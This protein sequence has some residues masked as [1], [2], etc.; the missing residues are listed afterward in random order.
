[1]KLTWEEV[2]ARSEEQLSGSTVFCFDCRQNFD[3]VEMPCLKHCISDEEREERD[4]RFERA[5]RGVWKP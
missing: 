3:A 5:V 4:E 1:M 2:R